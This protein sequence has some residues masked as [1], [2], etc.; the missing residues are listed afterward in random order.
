MPSLSELAT[1]ERTARMALFMMLVEPNDP[2]T[3]RIVARL[4][5]VETLWLAERD[6]AV[7]GQTQQ[8]GARAL[9]PRDFDWPAALNDIGDVAPYVLWTRDASSSLARPLQHFDWH[10]AVC[11]SAL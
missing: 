10:A 6:D 8:S 3:G 5:A 9:I 1:D 2:V 11:G 7:I 4:G